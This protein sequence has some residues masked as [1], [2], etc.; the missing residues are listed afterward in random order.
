MQPRK[1]RNAM[2][3]EQ[4]STQASH[5]STLHTAGPSA[6]AGGKGASVPVLSASTATFC[7]SKLVLDCKERRA[8]KGCTSGKQQTQL[9]AAG[10]AVRSAMQRYTSSK[11]RSTPV[12]SHPC[13]RSADAPSRRTRT[14]THAHA[15]LQNRSARATANTR[16]RGAA[17]PNVS[18]PPLQDRCWN[19]A[20]HSTAALPNKPQKNRRAL[21]AAGYE[22]CPLPPK[23]G[24]IENP[25]PPSTAPVLRHQDIRT[26][27][28]V[29]AIGMHALMRP[30]P[31]PRPRPDKPAACAARA[32]APGSCAAFDRLSSGLSSASYC[33]HPPPTTTELAGLA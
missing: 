24:I 27:G 11:Q 2:Q 12:A 31:R 18:P 29:E 28:H 20:E 32:A 9:C 19:L 4:R 26:P 33:K 21:C 22:P 30:R 15:L 23:K 17:A 8:S 1:K 14:A 10:S 13:Q 3:Q 6:S 16:V 7:V 25:G 5:N